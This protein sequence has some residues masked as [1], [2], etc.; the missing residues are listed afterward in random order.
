LIAATG[1][2][3]LA[4]AAA[5]VTSYPPVASSA[6]SIGRSAVTRPVS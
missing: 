6:T 1:S 4:R 5:T 3:A 2:S